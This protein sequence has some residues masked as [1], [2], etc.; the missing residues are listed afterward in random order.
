MSAFASLQLFGLSYWYVQNQ[1]VEEYINESRLYVRELEDSGQ[2]PSEIETYAV[3]ATQYAESK[4]HDAM[5][6][7]YLFASSWFLGSLE[8]SLNRPLDKSRAKKVKK[9]KLAPVE[10]KLV[11]HRHQPALQLSFAEE[12]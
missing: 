2:S 6:G 12:F 1:E 5:V 11:F 9:K 7:F 3:N 4:R 10:A 8:A